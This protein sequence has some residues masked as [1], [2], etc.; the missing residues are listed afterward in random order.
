MEPPQ[1]KPRLLIIWSRHYNATGDQLFE[2]PA[3]YAKQIARGFT[4]DP[5]RHDVFKARNL[6][7]ANHDLV[8]IYSC[9]VDTAL[10]IAG[11]NRT[12]N[13]FVPKTECSA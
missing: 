8:A 1:A 6:I 2:L 5:F 13:Q 10:N 7:G 9:R 4:I 3:R 11:L 12:T